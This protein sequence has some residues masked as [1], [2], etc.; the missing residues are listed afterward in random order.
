LYLKGHYKRQDDALVLFVSQSV[1][2]HQFY[3]TI[4]KG[5]KPPGYGY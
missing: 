3:F 1:C 4:S 2:I 5:A